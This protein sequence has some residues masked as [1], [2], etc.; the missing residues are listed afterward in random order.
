M[1]A[2]T[3]DFLPADGGTMNTANARE[4]FG[5]GQAIELKASVITLDLDGVKDAGPSFEASVCIAAS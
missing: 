2:R 1:Y 4:H 3:A 5:T